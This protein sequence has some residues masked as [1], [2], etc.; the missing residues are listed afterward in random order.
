MI[1]RRFLFLCRP[2]KL[3]HQIDSLGEPELAAISFTHYYRTVRCYNLFI[4]AFVHGRLEE[5][6]NSLLQKLDVFDHHVEHEVVTLEDHVAHL[7]EKLDLLEREGI[8]AH[9]GELQEVRG[10]N[11]TSWVR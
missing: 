10:L 11:R 1:P 9:K 5:A 8:T 4:C 2:L 3:P 6:V 7:H